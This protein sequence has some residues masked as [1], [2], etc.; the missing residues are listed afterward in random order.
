VGPIAQ[1]KASVSDA[2]QLFN[3]MFFMGFMKK[4]NADIET[5][6]D[7]A[8]TR[9]ENDG[10]GLPAYPSEVPLTSRGEYRGNKLNLQTNI[11]NWSITKNN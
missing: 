10:S 11:F 1:A 6:T 5:E 4:N 3:L 2:K 7:E 9:R 8:L